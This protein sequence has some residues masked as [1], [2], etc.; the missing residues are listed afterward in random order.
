MNTTAESAVAK[1]PDKDERILDVATKV[2]AEQ[3]FDGAETQTIADLAEVGKG[4]VY[5]YYKSKE[6][7]F[8]A[9]ADC[10]MKKLER[11]ILD[12]MDDVEGTLQSIRHVGIAYAEFFQKH[13]K[14]VEILIQERA[15]F[16][17]SIPDTHLVY[18]QKNRR[19][20]ED[21]LRQGIKEG[22][23]RDVN[24]RETTNAFA[25]VLFG[26]VVCGCIEGSS[27]R[28]KRMAGHAVELFLRGI[29]TDASLVE[30][31]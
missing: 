9:V 29:V 10:G 14:L 23:I 17:G 2:F 22:V 7:L 25:N 28:L 6:E 30:G 19:V 26:T 16:R 3:G 12:G 11:H 8:L 31:D 13:P 20:F 5:R 24:V 1:S 4:T 18:R 15:A 21:I 27:K